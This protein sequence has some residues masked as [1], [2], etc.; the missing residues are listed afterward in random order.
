MLAQV[1]IK[2]RAVEESKDQ[3]HTKKKK[4]KKKKSIWDCSQQKTYPSPK[5]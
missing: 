1:G 3:H 4:K 2:K 5:W